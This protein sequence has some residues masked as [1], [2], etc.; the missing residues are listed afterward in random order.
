M[1]ILHLLLA[2]AVAVR[3]GA[4]TAVYQIQILCGLLTCAFA[5]HM[6]VVKVADAVLADAACGVDV[7]SC[8]SSCI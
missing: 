3:A 5:V 7:C 1:Q 2:C 4:F 8:C 6:C